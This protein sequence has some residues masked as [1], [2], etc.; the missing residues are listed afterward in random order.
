[1]RYFYKEFIKI[2]YG[3]LSKNGDFRNFW[4]LIRKIRSG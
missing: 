3:F 2:R 1:L 4:I